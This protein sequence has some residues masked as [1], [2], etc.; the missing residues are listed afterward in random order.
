MISDRKFSFGKN[1]QLFLKNIN[2]D[3]V[4]QATL[5][6]VDFL[7][8]ENFQDKTFIDVGCGSGIFSHAALE[9]GA[10]K[11]VSFDVDHFSVKCCE[12]MRKKAKS[13]RNWEIIEGSILDN[14]FISELGTFDIV[15][16]WG[17]LHHTGNMW[18][19]IRNSAS[20]VGEG[21]CYYIAIYNK[22]EGRKGSAHWL[23]RKKLYN[24]S[25]KVLKY[26]LE[27]GHILRF[28]AANIRGKTNPFKIIKNYSSLRGMS[29]RCDITDWVGGYPYEFAKVEEVF[30]FMKTNFP[31][32]R[33]I[34]IKTTNSLSNNWYLFQRG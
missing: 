17:V 10:K 6:L 1:W 25:G 23:R 29:W 26:C 15:Y 22:V 20:L 18:E 31:E 14:K 30:M 19:A 9:L 21:G 24:T 34:N 33:L 13:S 16:S 11:I 4:N 32:F 8:M 27:M 28:F 2:E 7:E 5:S 3:K 12:Y